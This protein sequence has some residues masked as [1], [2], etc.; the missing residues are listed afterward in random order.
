[1]NKEQTQ[2]QNIPIKP[3]KKTP[4]NSPVKSPVKSPNRLND[5]F[6]GLNYII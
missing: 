3:I 1:M 5:P 4:K 2:P 6:L